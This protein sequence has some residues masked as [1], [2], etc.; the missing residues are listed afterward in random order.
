MEVLILSG[1]VG[2]GKTS[3]AMAMHDILSENDVP[4]ACLDLDWF[5]YSWPTVGAFNSDMVFSALERVWPVYYAAGAR[6]LVLARVVETREELE[7]YAEVLGN[8]TITLCRV[9][10]S[11]EVRKLR[12]EKRESGDS[13][14]WHLHRTVELEEIL[15]EARLE[16]F[17]IVNEAELAERVAERTLRQLRWLP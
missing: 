12:L 4:H 14:K 9:T 13:L 5:A 11:E 1:T 8:P 16:S 15:E 17:V 7:R 3:I 6:K 10:A 2:A